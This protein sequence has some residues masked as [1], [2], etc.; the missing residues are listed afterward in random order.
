MIPL[1]Q[2]K[3][4]VIADFEQ[5][6]SNTV[7]G[8]V[9]M[10]EMMF[11]ILTSG[12][13]KNKIRSLIRE[14]STNAID[15]HVMNNNLETPVDVKI[16]TALDPQFVIRDYGTGLSNE[17]VGKCFGCFGYSTKRDS[18]EVNGQ[19]GVGSKVPFAYTQSFVLTSFF[20]GMKTIFNLF[21]AE[22]GIPRITKIFE[23]V[24]DEPSGIEIKISVFHEDFSDFYEEAKYVY[25]AFTKGKFNIKGIDNIQTLEN[26]IEWINDKIGY[27]KERGMFYEKF[28]V[29]QENVVYPL[30]Y[31]KTKEILERVGINSDYNFGSLPILI[32][33]KNGQMSYNVSR[34]TIEDTRENYMVLATYFKDFKRD[35]DECI[36]KQIDKI[37]NQYQACKRYKNRSGFITNFNR[38]R[39]LIEQK[40]FK[41]QELYVLE[42]YKELT[43]YEHVIKYNK[44][45]GN[46]YNS[47]VIE[48]SHVD[49][50]DAAGNKIGEK[51][52][53]SI[54][55]EDIHKITVVIVDDRKKWMNKLTHNI[56]ST[57]IILRNHEL[58]KKEGLPKYIAD[59]GDDVEIRYTSEMNAIE[60]ERTKVGKWFREFRKNS[61]S[62]LQ[63]GHNLTSYHLDDL[64][65][66]KEKFYIYYTTKE[67]V[68]ASSNIINVNT[69][70]Y[71][72]FD[73]LIDKDMVILTVPLG[74]K[75]SVE[76]RYGDRAIELLP[77]IEKKILEKYTFE[78]FEKYI[79]MS[80]HNYP[81]YFKGTLDALFNKIPDAPYATAFKEFK[82]IKKEEQSDIEKMMQFVN[83]K[84][85]FNQE[86]KDVAHLLT[87][88][89]NFYHEHYSLIIEHI[90]Y[91]STD[92]QVHNARQLLGLEPLL[93]QFSKG[94]NEND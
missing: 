50:K 44:K 89:Y 83:V 60:T 29:V 9:E 74:R 25:S 62:T 30:D 49:V 63:D 94:E 40:G 64:V 1:N 20:N 39:V 59:M 33:I 19:F 32:F 78:E 35:V 48:Y 86:Q 28:Y 55:V 41:Y 2:T 93:T 11:K 13:Y 70:R 34:E 10:S 71:D 3:T 81:S 43:P 17:M 16:P 31:T 36:K 69:I 90:R 79:M 23:E 68:V 22:D 53:L 26:N 12:I 27:L 51:W 85:L 46:R 57:C 15:S 58:I 5:D 67:G 37:E 14:L 84:K 8:S 54:S 72:W 65:D 66:D 77:Y 80:K 87:I 7:K 47:K 42:D 6:D 76:K 92:K 52:G 91:S 24:S 21:L 4:E 45:S 88:I 38:E 61:H 56:S 75:E 18:N 82:E 73:F